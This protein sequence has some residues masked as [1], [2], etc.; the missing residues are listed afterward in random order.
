EIRGID[1]AAGIDDAE[2]AEL[3]AAFNE[4]SV[5]VLRGQAVTPECQIALTKRLGGIDRYTF[6]E[7]AH[8][9]HPE[10]LRVSNLSQDG[11]PL[12]NPK[13]GHTWHTDQSYVEEPPRC[14]LLYALE[15]PE[16]DGVVLGDT[17]YA[18]AAA[19]YDALPE[20]M[21]QKLDGLQAVHQFAARKRGGGKNKELT[22]KQKADHPDVIHPVV[23][24]HPFTGRKCIFVR[25]GECTAIVGL[26]DDEGLE[27]IEMLSHHVTKQEFIHRH[28]WQ[29]GDLVIWDNCA[30]QH[31]AILDYAP[32]LRR[33]MHRTTVKGTKPV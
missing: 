32:P 2:F 4:H 29:Q 5:V 24:V 30:L 27:I 22:A 23:R 14:T 1:L 31:L 19:A 17:L 12:G 3:D 6:T 8:P 25:E 28:K 16:K 9:D 7:H 13:A 18:S 10:V 21:K 11:K 15:V 20:E 33:H 26:A